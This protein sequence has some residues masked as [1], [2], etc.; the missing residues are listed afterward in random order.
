MQAGLGRRLASCQRRL[1]T[2]SSNNS[3]SNGVHPSNDNGEDDDEDL[4]AL[5]GMSSMKAAAAA[6]VTKPVVTTSPFVRPLSPAEQL[7]QEIAQVGDV[8]ADDI[9]KDLLSPTLGYDK[10]K[11]SRGKKAPTRLGGKPNKTNQS[12]LNEIEIVDDSASSILAGA[13]LPGTSNQFIDGDVDSIEHKVRLEMQRKE[14]AMDK[15]RKEREAARQQREKAF[16]GQNVGEVND[17][18]EEFGQEEEFSDDEDYDVMETDLQEKEFVLRVQ[19]VNR[20]QEHLSIKRQQFH[21]LR[22]LDAAAPKI[23]AI[24]EA[25]RERQYIEAVANGEIDG[26]G[27]YS[28]LNNRA[29]PQTKKAKDKPAVVVDEYD[30]LDTDG[31]RALLEENITSYQLNQH[32]KAERDSKKNRQRKQPQGKLKQSVPESTFVMTPLHYC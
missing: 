4:D 10:T 31:L 7:K 12:A 18:T 15:G 24:A 2:N 30:G 28:D 8:T 6:S 27:G 19:A 23:R 11:T 17:E 5:L 14:A 13:R 20:R 1:S 22:G 25:R 29:I 26:F 16:W 21:R 3:G 9:L 32:R